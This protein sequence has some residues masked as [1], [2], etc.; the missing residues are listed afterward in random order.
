MK[1]PENIEKKYTELQ[2]DIKQRLIEFK[3]V[4]KNKYFY[5]LCF[6][7]CT[8]QSKARSA[9]MVQQKLEE[10]DFFNNE[11]DPTD[12]LR[13][14]ENYIRFH[15]QKSKRLIRIKDQWQEINSI[16]ESAIDPKE[17]RNW[18]SKNVNGIGMKESAHYLRNIGYRG[19]GILD[20]HI[21]KHLVLC[22][23]YKKIP[24][25]STEKR[26]NL[27]ENKFRKLSKEI[28]IDM[29]ELDLLF[30]SY[31]AGEILK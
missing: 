12:I 15:N 14:P 26:Y 29:D 28:G 27:V 10:I 9:F 21:L 8:P 1:L 22:E 6:C 24:N 20:R 31:E 18:L 5:E 30:W 19:L 11:L 3:N 25:I 23:A 17:K 4:P 16:L 2:D 13:T 7:I